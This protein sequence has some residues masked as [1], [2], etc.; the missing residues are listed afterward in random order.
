[1]KL[2]CLNFNENKS[3]LRLKLEILN[4]RLFTFLQLINRLI[5]ENF[6]YKKKLV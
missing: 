6:S 1:M 3:K 2:I 5:K 4:K